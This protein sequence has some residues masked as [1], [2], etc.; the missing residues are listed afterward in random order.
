MRLWI[1]PIHCFG[2]EVKNLSECPHGTESVKDTDD[3]DGLGRSPFALCRMCVR[4]QNMLLGRLDRY[5]GPYMRRTCQ[6]QACPVG[7]QQ[8]RHG[9]QQQSKH[10]GN[11]S[12]RT[13]LNFLP[14]R[15]SHRRRASWWSWHFTT[16]LPIRHA[17]TEILLRGKIFI[18]KFVTIQPLHPR[19]GRS[20]NLTKFL[21]YFA[22]IY[23]KGKP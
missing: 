23:C 13:V 8:H 14:P 20:S 17:Y 11:P 9:E 22:D 12:S 15:H 4:R 16:L 2:G 7:N 18:Q 19:G 6:S 10:H 1:C 3:L 5:I 21:E